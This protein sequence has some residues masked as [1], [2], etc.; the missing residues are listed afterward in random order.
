MPARLILNAD[1]FGLTPGI[2]R[3]IAELHSAGVLTSATLMANGPAF[4]DAVAIARAHPSLAIGCHI[5]LVDGVPVSDPTRIPT[6][7]GPDRKSFRPTLTHFIRDLLLRRINPEEVAIE[8]RA[9]IQKITA[10]GIP[11]THIDTHKHTHIFP[12]IARPLLHVAA[13]AN[14]RAIRNPFEPG[15]SLALNNG[16]PSRRLAVKLLRPLRARFEALPQIANRTILT[17]DGTLAISAAGQLTPATLAAI[18]RALPSTG[19]FELCCH[20][21]YNDADL[22]RIPTRLR[23]HRDIERAALLTEI[24]RRLTQ[25]NPPQLIHYGNL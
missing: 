25:P 6:L 15:W 11:I 2:N 19:T 17:T 1:D 21:G 12:S 20:P 8:A 23:A 4:S 5:V 24:P 22:D 13:A 14:I 16:S 10:A 18:L 7:L 3:A 9:Q